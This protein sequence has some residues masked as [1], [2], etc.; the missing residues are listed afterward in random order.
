MSLR[1]G[2]TAPNF[3]AD[4]TDG[5]IDFHGEEDLERIFRMLVEGSVG[6]R[7]SSSESE[8]ARS[9]DK[10]PGAIVAP[11]LILAVTAARQR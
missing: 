5:E 3:T 11:G 10:A 4:T 6:S 9:K 7:P 8:T 2:D 1:L